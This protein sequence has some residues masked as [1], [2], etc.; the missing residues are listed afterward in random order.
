MYMDH[1]YTILLGTCV[2]ILL[3]DKMEPGRTIGKCV[4]M[5]SNMSQAF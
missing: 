3:V 1:T 4:V 2:A 5:R